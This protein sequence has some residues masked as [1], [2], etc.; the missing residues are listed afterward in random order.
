[1]VQ[2]LSPPSVGFP[3]L[4]HSSSGQLV[5]RDLVGHLALLRLDELGQREHAAKDDAGDDGAKDEQTNQTVHR[6]DAPGAEIQA[7]DRHYAPILGKC[8]HFGASIA[9]IGWQIPGGQNTLSPGRGY[10]TYGAAARELT[11]DTKQKDRQAACAALA[12][13]LGARS[14][15][16]VGMMGAGKTTVGRRL[17]AWLRIPFTDADAEIEHAAGQSIGDIFAN[18]GEEAFRAGERRVIARLLQSG[19]QVLATGGGAFISGE[20]RAQIEEAGVSVWLRAEFDT[21]MRRVRRRSTRPLLSGSDR[22]QVLEK[23]MKERYPIYALA[24]VTVTT[25][26]VPHEVIVGEIVDALGVHLGLGGASA[27]EDRHEP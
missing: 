20:T 26:D 27:R 24:D 22:E 23:L 25:R 17:A 19:P 12:A 16:M 10:E 4:S 8:E 18:H 9:F 5:P 3:A 1:M 6:G 2:A 15:V 13:A 7:C 11:M 14:I 21:L